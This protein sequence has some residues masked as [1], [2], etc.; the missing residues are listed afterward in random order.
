[1]PLV[2]DE[3]RRIA[4]SYVR[5]ERPGQTLQATALVNEAFVRMAAER[6]RHF[7]G[8]THFLAI[9]ALSMRQILIQRARARRA[10]KRGGAPARVT[11]D[12][13]RVAPDKIQAGF[14]PPD[15]DRHND[16]D[17]LA[18]DEALRRLAELDD[19]LARIVELRYFGG[20]T[21]EETAEVVGV[22]PATV[23]RQWTLA[24]VWLKRALE[25]EPARTDLD[26][27]RAVTPEQ[28]ARLKIVFQEALD[29]PSDVRR[30]WLREECGG[31]SALLRE[32][33]SL[34]DTFET[35]GDFL[36]EPAQVDPDDLDTLPP[37]TRVGS[38]Q[39][40]EE[41]GRGGMGVVYLAEDVRLGRRVA[42]KS[43]PAAVAMQ[44]ELRERLRREARAAATISHPAVAVVYALE[45]LGDHL[46]IASEYVQGET[47]RDVIAQGP[48]ATGA[49]TQH[50]DRHRRRA[51]G[52]AR[53]RRDPSRPEAGERADQVG[54]QR[55]GR[56]F[57]DR[58]CRGRRRLA[59]DADRLR[60][61]HARLHGAG[62][63]ARRHRSI[64]A[65]TSMP[66]ASC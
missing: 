43:L 14:A 52:R 32:A 58:A 57:R 29:Q 34:L 47:L 2:Y 39:I 45:E 16:I 44:P 48:L 41:I 38:Y 28:F 49:R 8:R 10:L 37:G 30:A 46:F 21:V 20:L 31:D 66:G 65:R 9:A 6:T 56:G 59:S 27:H 42:L 18:L 17:V 33:E 50:R 62:A 54:R 13:E 15:Q 53:G 7:N 60:A 51:V 35:A 22:S 5:G 11:L 24:R 36:E 55:E 12:D 3:L 4:A 23:K 61:R 26:E 63:T 19:T 64:R 40:L 25:G 1:M